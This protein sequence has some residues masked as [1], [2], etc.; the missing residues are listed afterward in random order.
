MEK[1]PYNPGIVGLDGKSWSQMKSVNDINKS[2]TSTSY[3]QQTKP[4]STPPTKT[5]K[6]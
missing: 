3:S 5:E 1:K 4:Q 2:F 6:K